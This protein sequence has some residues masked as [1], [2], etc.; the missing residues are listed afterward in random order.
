MS[1]LILHTAEPCFASPIFTFEVP[2][3]A[4]L[5]RD[6]VRDI[7]AYRADSEG[8]NR[9]NQHGWHSQTDFFRRQEPSFKT[10]AGH[11]SSAITSATRQVSP[12][13]DLGKRVYLLQGWVNVNGRGAFNTP[14]AHPDHEWSGS[15]YVKVPPVPEGSRS[16]CIEFLDPRGSVTQMDALSSGYFMPKIRKKPQEGMLLL[17]PSYLRHW[18]YPNEQDDIRI[19]IAFNAKIKT[20]DQIKQA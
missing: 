9:S 1:S 15:Y 19:S 13:L 14:H 11:I 12:K 5:N 2:E 20:K 4:A 3:A 18:V 16:G 17:F 10:L 7:E 6:L 8:M